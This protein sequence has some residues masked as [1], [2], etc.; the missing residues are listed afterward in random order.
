MMLG[1]PGCAKTPGENTEAAPVT[2]EEALSMWTDSETRNALIGYVEAV[3]D[4]NGPDYIP[5]EDRTRCSAR[6]ILI[7][8]TICCCFTG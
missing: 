7:I 5:V 2:G 1:I 6:R 8:S 3:T 4:V